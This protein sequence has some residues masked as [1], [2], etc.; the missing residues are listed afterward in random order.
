MN[1]R[2][3]TGRLG[4]LAARRHLESNGYTILGAN[5]RCG[6][7]EIDI[8]AEQD[9]TLVFAEVR[10]RRGQSLGTPEESITPRKR[11]QMLTAAQAYLAESDGWH[12]NWRIDIVAVE[13]D[14]LDRVSRLSLIR[15]A[16]EL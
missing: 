8:V 9:G 2:Q 14:Y 5:V 13:L 11:Q 16:V 6:R 10:T 12:L 4:E 7:S 1:S 15:N 3:E